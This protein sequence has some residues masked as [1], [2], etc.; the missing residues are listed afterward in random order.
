ML[1]RSIDPNNPSHLLLGTDGGVYMS[2]DKGNNWFFLNCIP[3]S[4]FYHVET[5]DANP[6]NIY[7]GLQDNGSWM[8]PSQSIGGIDNGDWVNVGF[9]D[10]FWVQPDPNDHD[11]LYSEYQGGHASRV[12]RK[13]NEYLDIQPQIGR[14]HV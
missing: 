8:T 9:G 5:D 13:T 10:G 4:M 14:A 2:M 6:Y 3:V 7:G 12:N 1:F 11:I